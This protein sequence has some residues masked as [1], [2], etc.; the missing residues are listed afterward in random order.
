[1]GITDSFAEIWV[2]GAAGIVSLV[3]TFVILLR[4]PRLRLTK[5]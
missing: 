2:I 1:M 3:A 5:G 4:W